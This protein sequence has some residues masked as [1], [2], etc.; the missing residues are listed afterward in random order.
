MLIR[1]RS[2]FPAST[3]SKAAID[4]AIHD[5]IGK[6]HGIRDRTSARLNLKSRIALGDLLGGS[7]GDF[8]R[9]AEG[10]GVVRVHAVSYRAAQQIADA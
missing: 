8:V 2:R 4:I 10:E 9:L 7:P 6:A 5:I 1:S 3:R